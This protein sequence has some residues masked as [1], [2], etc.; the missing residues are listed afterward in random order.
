MNGLPITAADCV[1]VS[2]GRAR[3]QAPVSAAETSSSRGLWTQPRGCHWG[4]TIKML[5]VFAPTSNSSLLQFLVTLLSPSIPSPPDG[6]PRS[7]PLNINVPYANGLTP[8]EVD[9]A[10]PLNVNPLLHLHTL[11]CQIPPQIIAGASAT[12]KGQPRRKEQN[13][14]GRAGKKEEKKKE[15][16]VAAN[17]MHS[18]K[19]TSKACLDCRVTAGSR[20]VKWR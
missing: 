18:I 3:L 14:G 16:K 10:P 20:C 13:G 6:R 15:N 9:Q 2:W 19:S 7:P 12:A 11:K 8:A 1:S 5:F 4:G 17:H